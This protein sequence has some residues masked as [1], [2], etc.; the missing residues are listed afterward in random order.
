MPL[1]LPLPRLSLPIYRYRSR[2]SSQILRHK[3]DALGFYWIPVSSVVSISSVSSED[4]KLGLERINS[5]MTSGNDATRASARGQTPRGQSVSSGVRIRLRKRFRYPSRSISCIQP[6]ANMAIT[7]GSVLALVCT[8]FAT[9][10]RNK[11]V[12][13]R[14]PANSKGMAEARPAHHFKSTRCNTL[15][16][17]RLSA[18]AKK[19]RLLKLGVVRRN[20]RCS[21]EEF[22]SRAD[23]S[24]TNPSWP[25]SQKERDRRVRFG[26]TLFPKDLARRVAPSFPIEFLSRSRPVARLAVPSF[27]EARLHPLM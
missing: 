21:N 16:S 5:K 7:S 19:A 27:R 10:K 13:L 17:G 15:I 18:K 20:S 3:M 14:N 25:I 6:P 24:A 11:L 2:L 12:F 26:N 4:A 9:W 8:Q 22:C 1:P 23:T